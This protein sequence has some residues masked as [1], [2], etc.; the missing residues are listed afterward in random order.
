M[1]K[2]LERNFDGNLSHVVIDQFDHAFALFFNEKGNM[3]QT[4]E[5][6]YGT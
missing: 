6:N 1:G 5:K 3:T 4:H 2:N